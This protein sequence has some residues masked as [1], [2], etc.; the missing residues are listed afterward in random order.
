MDLPERGKE[1]AESVQYG[2]REKG[3]PMDPDVECAWMCVSQQNANCS[4]PRLF[5]IRC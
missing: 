3:V 4:Q 5:C 1:N 2:G